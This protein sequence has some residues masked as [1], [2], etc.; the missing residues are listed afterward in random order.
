MSINLTPEVYISWIPRGQI[1]VKPEIY[2]SIILAPHL[3]TISADT[4]RN[5]KNLETLKADTFRKTGKAETLQADSYRKICKTENNLADTF[6]RIGQTEKISADSSRTINFTENIFA[7][8]QRKVSNIEKIIADTLREVETDLAEIVADTFLQIG[9]AEKT[10]ANSLREIVFAEKICAD[11]FRAINQTA[12]IIAD[13]FLQVG[14]T[15]KISADT[16]R[17]TSNIENISADTLR[18]TLIIETISADTERN[19]LEFISAD[20]YRQVVKVERIVADTNKRIPHKLIYAVNAPLLKSAKLQDTSL[21]N[22]FKDY[23]LTALNITLQ[24]KTLSDTFQ[25][26]TV[27]ELEINDAVTGKF[28]DYEFNFLVEE[29]NRQDLIQSVKGM[30]DQDILLYSNFRIGEKVILKWK[31]KSNKKQSYE[32]IQF[33]NAASY[34]WAIADAMGLTGDFKFDD[35]VPYNMESSINTTYASVLSNLFGWSSRVPQRQINVFIRAGVLHCIQRGMEETVFDIS[36]L[37]HTRPIVNK[38]LLRTMWNRSELDTD[39]DDDETTDGEIDISTPFTGTIEFTT[40]NGNGIVHSMLRYTAGY[41]VEEATS[42]SGT[43]G[44]S[45]SKSFYTYETFHSKYTSG[46]TIDATTKWG[47]T[48]TY[49]LTK[50]TSYTLNK[51]DSIEHTSGETTGYG[52]NNSS[53]STSRTKYSYKE[54]AN[55]DVYLGVEYE[56]ISTRSGSSNDVSIT[57]RTTTHSPLGNGWYAQAV[58]VDGEP[59]GGNLSQGKPGNAVTPYTVNEVQKT[60]S[61]AKIQ[62][63][64]NNSDSDSDPAAKKREEQYKEIRK[65][66]SRV[67]DISFPIRDLGTV[68]ELTIALNWLNRKTQEEV[69][70]DIT[71]NIVKGVPRLLHIIDFTE[72]IK[73]DGKEYFLV[74][75]NIS[76]TPKSF[77]QKLR[78][79]RWY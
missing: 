60:F 9:N 78:L 19:L 1:E 23:G 29:T 14:N 61:G 40:T 7:D 45:E 47:S 15:E 8:T 42:T 72:R 58:F 65:Q 69:S 24:E 70:V 62:Y 63:D 30:Y 74:S 3:E 59:Q 4:C 16:T 20:T 56:T 32:F 46:N 44:Q 68:Q 2:A 79:V 55:G 37:P 26:D 41:L 67:M 57:Q 54:T 10:S 53:A 18:Q 36:D 22:T 11:T 77:I 66:L 5:V 35:F 73:L 52:S 31:D 6:R 13:T 50:K 48:G 51:M 75:N 21:I 17:I 12:E 71:D 76:F 64:K 38:K 43:S 27:Q 28:L 34:L 49:Y 25:L 33:T 39:D